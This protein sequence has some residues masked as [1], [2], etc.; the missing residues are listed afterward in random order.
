MIRSILALAV[1]GTML[2]SCSTSI[3]QAGAGSSSETVIGKI[4]TIDGRPA[5]DT[6][7]MLIPSDYDPVSSTAIDNRKIYSDTTTETGDYRMLVSDTGRFNVLAIQLSLGTRSLIS[8]IFVHGDTTGVQPCT[9]KAPGAIKVILPAGVDTLNGYV[10]IPGTTTLARLSS[11]KG[12]VI[13]DSVPAGIASSIYYG[14]ESGSVAPSPILDSIPVLS[15]D[16]T[17]TTYSAWKFSKRCYFN[18]TASGAGVSNTVL[19]F[20]VLVRLTAAN[21]S[22]SGTRKNG[23]D[24]RFIKADGS[25]CA[26]EIERWDSAGAVAEV[27]VNVDTV[28][29]SDNAHYVKMLWGNPNA[30]GAANAGA[31][32]DTANGFQGVW[33]LSDPDL[34]NVKDATGNHFDGTPSDT[35]P[36]AAI[37]AIGIAKGFKGPSSYFD[38]KNT[39]SGKL[40]FPENGVY[41]L[42]A[43][44]Y[45]DT[46]DNKF[47]AIVGKSDNQ[48]FLKLKPY[49]PP[50]P[51]RWEFAEFHDMVGWQI[52]D[53][54][55]TAQQWKYLVGVRQGANQ[56]FYLDGVL[57]DT[58]IEIRADSV[59]RYTGD[60]VT[61]GKFLTYS[62]IDAGYC[63]FSGKIDEVR[64]SSVARS[65]DWIKLCYMN[66]K[67]PDALLSFK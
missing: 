20:P 49:Y 30:A 14:L 42:S 36:V 23:E 64:I 37:G 33:H 27:W 38:M 28:F 1:V 31:V 15:G 10:Y 40:N 5:I 8:G 6:K 35:A 39:A 12:Y 55:A 3:Q 22:F 19:H 13:L 29:G 43:W 58:S 32:F 56:F 63:P 61:I 18:T 54:L 48:Y 57:V 67:T 53:T 11:T 62:A 2:L 21:F 66:Q 47:H 65:A 4:S 24:I 25:P 46:L 59:A 34:A 50:N 51:M 7:V 16:T 52:T 41:T 44:V 9:L 17:I 60:D 26:Y 45:A